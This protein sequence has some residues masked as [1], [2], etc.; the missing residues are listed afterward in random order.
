MCL[1]VVRAQMSET[2]AR[3]P[4]ENCGK[5]VY[6]ELEL[7]GHFLC[8]DCFN[9]PDSEEEEEKKIERCTQCKQH[10]DD[11][12]NRIAV[13]LQCTLEVG[14]MVDP[15]DFKYFCTKECARDFFVAYANS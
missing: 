2:K 8:S 12:K 13:H 4:C 6:V 10:I 5:P 11:N 1:S 7:G 3:I 15:V 9:E 14:Q